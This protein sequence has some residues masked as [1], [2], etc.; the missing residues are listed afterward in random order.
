MK[1][2]SSYSEALSFSMSLADFERGSRIPDHHTFHLDRMNLLLQAIGEPQ[3]HIPSVHIAGTKGKGS[4]S[5]M[6]T[7]VMTASGYKTGLA[8]SPHLHSVTERIRHGLKPITQ[9]EFVGL[10]RDLWP[11]VEDVSQSGGFGG[12]TWFEFMVAA[13]FYNF[14]SN[15]LDFM[16][17]ET[18]LGGRLDA[19]NVIRPEVSAITSISLDHTNILGDTVEKIAAEKGGIIKPDVPV[20]VAAQPEEVHKVLQSI[21]SKNKSDYIDVSEKYSVRSNL[22]DLT[23][24]AIE[25]HSDEYSREFKLP[26]LGS[27]QV[28]NTAVA[29]GIV[30]VLKKRGYEIGELEVIKGMEEVKWRARFDVL[31]VAYPAV[32]VDGAHNP[33]SMVRLVETFEA[34]IKFARVIVLFGSLTNHEMGDMLRAFKELNCEI[35]GVKSRHPKASRVTEIKEK[36]DEIDLNFVKGFDLV[37]EGFTH[38][39][40]ISKPNDLILGTGSLSV[41]AE[42]IETYEGIVPETYEC[43][44]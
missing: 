35:I 14:A 42:I 44:I 25:I 28:E 22:A 17:V 1:L 38:A 21:A 29:L 41:A 13:A 27:H 4:T 36:C 30:D 40:S 3:N 9:L 31:Q 43:F 19:T 37:S 8:T 24:Q 2:P 32:I 15:E 12:V 20:V 39:L 33:Y 6:V 34:H 26:L 5:A 18:G 11:A 16:I 7:S 10:V 23:G